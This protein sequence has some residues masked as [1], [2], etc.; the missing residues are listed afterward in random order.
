MENAIDH[1]PAGGTVTVVAK[2]SAANARIDVTDQGRGV[3]GI[4]PDRVFDR[5]AHGASARTSRGETRTRHGIGLAL[6]RE[7][8]ERYDGTVD[9]VR[10]G[11]QGSTFKLVLPLA[12][13]GAA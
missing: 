2:R 12:R 1:S 3:V 5:F 10:T 6:V 7:L 4:S 8:A 11:P 13:G 9:V